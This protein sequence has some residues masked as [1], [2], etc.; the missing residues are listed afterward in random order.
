MMIILILFINCTV[1]SMSRV[2]GS[3]YYRC[4]RFISLVGGLFLDRW[5][6]NKTVVLDGD[7]DP[8]EKVF[9]IPYLEV[10]LTGQGHTIRGYR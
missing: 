9:P 10:C 5:S 1:T 4:R 6:K 3:S 8:K 2:K 7:I